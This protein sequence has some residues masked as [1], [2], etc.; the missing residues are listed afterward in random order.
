MG[1]SQKY[2]RQDVV[3][4]ATHLFWEKGFHATSMRNLQDRIDM[5]PGSIYATFG[6]KEGLFKE[7]LRCY[8]DASLARLAACVEATDSPLDALKS[9]VKSVVLRS[10][11]NT[12]NEIC[13]LVKSIS[14]LTEDNAE[15]LSESKRL[16]KVMEDAFASLLAQAQVQ[17]ELD[18]SRDTRR[19]ARFIQMQ[20]IGLRAYTRT[21]E[22]AP[23][24]ELIDD[25]FTCFI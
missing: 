3:S 12:P 8:A 16:L 21:N 14:E 23:V 1:N 18:S 20:L 7:S 25:A 24:N 5:R 22:D 4:K 19:L 2:D 6:S 17:G 15:L 13:M 11:E 9:F 10:S